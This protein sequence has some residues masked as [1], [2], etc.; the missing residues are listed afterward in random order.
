MK[1][2]RASGASFELKLWPLLLATL[3]LGLTALAQN[4][5]APP[6]TGPN[7]QSAAAPVT[8]TL[9]DALQ[10]AQANSPDFRAAL[11]ELGLAHEDRVQGRA[12]L[13]PNVNYNTDFIYSQGN[14]TRSN[15]AAYIANNG[16]HEYLSQGNVHQVFSLAAYGDYRRAAAAEA[17]AAWS[18][19]LFS[20]TTDWSSPSASTELNNSPPKKPE[21]SS[22]SVRNSKKAARS[23]TPT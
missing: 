12:G 11:T 17:L 5:P 23:R 18:S 3:A 7:A 14:G 6:A 21:N 16:V 4:E 2:A 10:R 22:T 13:L 19:Q 8:L 15:T 20:R 1:I 9:Q